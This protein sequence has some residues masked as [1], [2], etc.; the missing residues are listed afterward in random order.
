MV[1]VWGHWGE[2]L[3]WWEWLCHPFYFY[4]YFLKSSHHP[5][6]DSTLM[7]P[8][9][10][11]TRSTDGSGQVLLGHRFRLPFINRIFILPVIVCNSGLTNNTHLSTYRQSSARMSWIRVAILFIF[12]N[13]FPDIPDRSTAEWGSDL[14]TVS[15]HWDSVANTMYSLQK[16]LHLERRFCF[17]HSSEGPLTSV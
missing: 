14:D 13:L 2:G 15:L 4:F 12:G 17:N 7:T 5:V 11:V 9:S 1:I 10:G 3:P 8:S 6:W 16:N